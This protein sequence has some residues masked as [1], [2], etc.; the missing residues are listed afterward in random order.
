MQKSYL[1]NKKNRVLVKVVSD[2][3]ILIFLNLLPLLDF[4]RISKS[5]MRVW[6]SKSMP[7]KTAS[8]I[9]IKTS[10]KFYFERYCKNCWLRVFLPYK[11]I[12]KFLLCITYPISMYSINQ[13]VTTVRHLKRIMKTFK[14]DDTWLHIL[15]NIIT[16]LPLRWLYSEIL[17]C[18]LV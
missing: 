5:C 14:I 9:L 8:I 1:Q 15:N 10:N 18:T 13:K 2:I 7:I 11:R 3:L 4:S 6:K 12:N 16:F 17:F